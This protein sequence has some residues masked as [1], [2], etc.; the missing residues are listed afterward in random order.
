MHPGGQVLAVSAGGGRGRATVASG[1]LPASG[2][3][4]YTNRK[5]SPFLTLRIFGVSCLPSLSGFFYL[6]PLVEEEILFF[7]RYCLTGADAGHLVANAP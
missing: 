2:A 6:H 7:P 1:R 5:T 4:L 3:S